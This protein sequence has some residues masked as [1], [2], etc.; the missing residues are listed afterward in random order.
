[1]EFGFRRFIVANEIV[2]LSDADW[3]AQRL[4]DRD[5]LE[6]FVFVDSEE[7]AD[8]LSD[9]MAAVSARPLGVLIEM[10]IA[11]ARCG[12]RDVE[13]AVGLGRAIERKPGLAVMGVAG[14]EGV[15]GMVRDESTRTK[16]KTF[17]AVLADSYQALKEA[18]LTPDSGAFGTAGGSIYFDDVLAG[19][20]ERLGSA[21]GEVSFVLRSGCYI[22]QDS[23]TYR[24]Q[25]PLGEQGELGVVEKLRPAIEVVAQVISTPEPGFCVVN[26]GKR[27]VSYDIAPPTLLWQAD[28]GNPIPASESDCVGL[29]DQHAM[30]RGPAIPQLRVGERVGLG[31]SHPCTTFDKWRA[32]PLV[33]DQLNVRDLILVFV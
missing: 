29:N 30:F 19:W 11:G 22:T 14:F 16:A 24:T 31:I 18:G 7:A 12:L 20:R 10:G 25:S 23:G 8:V 21:G 1:M 9:A 2:N 4:Q 27:D 3:L 5:E 28:P 13:A 17:G 26:A 33:D 32:M 6:V 15:V